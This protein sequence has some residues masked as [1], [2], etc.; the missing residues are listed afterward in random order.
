MSTQG[1]THGD[2]LERT[3]DR[4]LESVLPNVVFDGWSDDA[5]LDGARMADADPLTVRRAFPG[6][7]E[8]LI[9][10]FAAW[11]DRAM[12]DA[13]QAHAPDGMRT[14]EKIRLAL[15]CHFQVLEPHREAVR[16]LIAHLA[17]PRNVALGLRLLHRTVDTIWYAAGDAAT[18]FNHYSKRA[19]LAGVLSSATFFWLDDASEDRAD[20]WAFIDR[21]LADVAGIGKATSAVKTVTGFLSHLPSP[22]RFAR[23]IRQRTGRSGGQTTTHMS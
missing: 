22:A 6:G 14:H 4:I 9:E 11:T 13:M 5:L 1:S 10:H 15:V 12:L 19:L 8:E 7:V 17:M 3:R 20:T 18:D 23:Q 2:T 21:R 16:R